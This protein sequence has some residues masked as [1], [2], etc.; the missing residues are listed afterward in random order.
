MLHF[1]YGIF[2]PIWLW[3]ALIVAGIIAAIVAYTG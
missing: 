3:I 1:A 2:V